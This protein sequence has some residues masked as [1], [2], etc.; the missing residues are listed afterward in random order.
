[1]MNGLQTLPQWRNYF[2][3]PDAGTLG[4][5]NAIYPVG[6][7]C[8]IFPVAWLADRYGR[9]LPMF[10]GFI[11][12]IIGPV[13]QAAA[14]NLPMFVVSRFIVGV[15]TVGIA[16]PSPV[17]ITELAY[18]TH[19]GKV[20]A[21]FNTFYYFGAIFAAWCTYGTF[22][23]QSDWSWRIPSLLQAGIPA[24]QFALFYWLPE[25]PR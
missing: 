10:I 5:M 6:K 15:A 18:P 3:N 8:G 1:M 20:T 14:Q 25:S 13:I 22:R 11:L 17:L 9:K 19:R 7:L 24:I 21:L 12:L 16:Q 4:A 2:N 23:L